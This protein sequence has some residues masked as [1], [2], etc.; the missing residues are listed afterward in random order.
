MRDSLRALGQKGIF[1]KAFT[2]P[3]IFCQLNRHLDYCLDSRGTNIVFKRLN[4]YVETSVL[5]EDGGR[6]AEA[7]SRKSNCDLI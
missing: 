6:R 5:Q 2:T 4:I 7:C 1:I 3:G